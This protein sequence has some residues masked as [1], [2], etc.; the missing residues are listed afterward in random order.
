MQ[1]TNTSTECPK[2]TKDTKH[3]QH[4][5]AEASLTGSI[6]R[7]MAPSKNTLRLPPSPPP[8]QLANPPRHV[9]QPAPRHHNPGDGIHEPYKQRQETGTLLANHKQDGLDVV[10]EEDAR[11]EVWV[12]GNRAGLAGGRVLVGEDEVFAVPV[13]GRGA[14]VGVCVQG[15]AALGVDGWDD[16]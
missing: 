6:I 16:R 12:F 5:A 3:Q 10:L 14:G 1:Y 2:P 8:E 15:E 11:D 13:C 4:I 7:L 9:I